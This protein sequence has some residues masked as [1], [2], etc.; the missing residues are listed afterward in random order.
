MVA[1]SKRLVSTSNTTVAF[2]TPVILQQ[3]F[4]TPCLRQSKQT[5]QN[6]SLATYILPIIF[7]LLLIAVQQTG[8]FFS[9]PV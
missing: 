4:Y 5:N 3:I 6:L 2:H 9:Y 8:I 1:L 7:D